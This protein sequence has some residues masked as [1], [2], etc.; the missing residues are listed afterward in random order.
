MAGIVANKKIME[1]EADFP[2]VRG[3]VS[4]GTPSNASLRRLPSTR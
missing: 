1:K 2:V 3:A 4:R